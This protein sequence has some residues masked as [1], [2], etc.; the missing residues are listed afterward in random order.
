VR[1]QQF[2]ELIAPTVSEFIPPKQEK[3]RDSPLKNDYSFREPQ[4]ANRLYEKILS[5]IEDENSSF[6]DC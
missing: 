6:L 3:A 2:I 4:I 1:K 5:P